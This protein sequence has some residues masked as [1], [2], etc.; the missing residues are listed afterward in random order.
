MEPG[1]GELAISRQCALLGLPRSTYYYQPVERD[2]QEL[3]L[4][5]RI[6]ETYTCFPFYG[7]PKMTAHL[8][9]TLGQPIN[10]KRVERLMR[11]MGLRAVA[12]RKG[13]SHS[14]PQHK[15]YPYLLR[16]LPIVRPNQV[17]A[18]DITYIGLA[19]G[20]LYLTAVIDW[21]SRYVLAWRLSNSLDTS[22][23]VETLDE[24]LRLGCPDIFNTDQGVQFTSGAF[25][26]RLEESGIRISMDG[27]GR[28]FDNIFTERLWRS[29]KYEEVYLCE[30]ADP[31][32]ADKALGAYFRFY[33]TQRPHQS[34]GY[35]TPQE[36][37]WANGLETANR[38]SGNFADQMN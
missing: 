29:V 32:A 16:D 18:S 20:F 7:S 38:K 33:N 6:D 4:M 27:R 22:F 37:H 3:E 12:P 35:R 11:V 26:K 28:C 8:S 36:V 24:A 13:L 2:P 10:H 5:R 1:H 25:T 9:R 30:Y 34:L 31:P 17:W 21:F 19:G 14:A 23:C 15:K